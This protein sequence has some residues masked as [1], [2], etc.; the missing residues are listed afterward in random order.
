M[1]VGVVVTTLQDAHDMMEQILSSQV[2]PA[3]FGL[4]LLLT[5]QL[6]TFTGTISGQ[7]VLQVPS[8]SHRK[9]HIR[10]LVLLN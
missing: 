5:S 7:V 6:S 9:T 8:S 10:P 3:V 2:A 4:A 1:G